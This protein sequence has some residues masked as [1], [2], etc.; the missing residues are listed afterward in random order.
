MWNI[1][2][3]VNRMGTLD[4]WARASKAAEPASGLK[5]IEMSCFRHTVHK[6][7]GIIPGGWEQPALG[8]GSSGR[9]GLGAGSS[10][11]FHSHLRA[12]ETLLK[13]A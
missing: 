12:M 7:K 8:L 6:A 3:F 13:T 2:L 11:P 1:I 5:K 10:K 4:S 9:R